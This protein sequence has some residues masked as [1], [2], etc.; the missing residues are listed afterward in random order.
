M[1]VERITGTPTEAAAS[2]SGR[3]TISNDAIFIAGTP[4]A[5]RDFDGVV[6][7]RGREE[8]DPARPRACSASSG[9]HSRGRAIASSSSFGLRSSFRYVNRGV[10]VE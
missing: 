6:V 8:G 4:T 1:P 9:C 7:E 10:F 5:A 3:S 2:M